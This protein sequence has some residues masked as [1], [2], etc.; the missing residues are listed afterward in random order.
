MRRSRPTGGVNHQQV[1]V[2]CMD[3]RRGFPSHVP[4]ED[5]HMFSVF[6]SL[7]VQAYWVEYVI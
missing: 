4:T 6:M 7:I 2:D 5:Q 3:P 1:L